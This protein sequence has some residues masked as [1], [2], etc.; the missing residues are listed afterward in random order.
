MISVYGKLEDQ[1]PEL[2]DIY[3]SPNAEIVVLS[4]LEDAEEIIRDR[5]GYAFWSWLRDRYHAQES[6]KKDAGQ[7]N[8]ESLTTICRIATGAMVAKAEEIKEKQKFTKKYKEE[9]TEM[10]ENTARQLQTA[11]RTYG[12]QEEY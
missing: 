2:L 6:E 4:K 12:H 10:L 9:L 1:Y 5:C 11:V 8:Y 7:E 3:G